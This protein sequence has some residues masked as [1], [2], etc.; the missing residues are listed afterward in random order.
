MAMP[1]LKVGDIVKLKSGGPDMTVDGLPEIQGPGPDPV[2]CLWF[3]NAHLLRGRFSL[4][5]L[6][7][8]REAASINEG[9]TIPS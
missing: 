1:E 9:V 6:K 4:K 7:R 3:D 2:D 8:L 5:A